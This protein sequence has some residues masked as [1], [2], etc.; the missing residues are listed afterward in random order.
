MMRT[1]SDVLAEGSTYSL[2]RGGR[3]SLR[4]EEHER[5]RA[6]TKQRHRRDERQEYR[7]HEEVKS[8]V[9][10]TPKGEY[11]QTYEGY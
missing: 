3:R 1:G 6:V 9:A 7:A 5:E 8:V 11:K 2:R 4:E 10:Y